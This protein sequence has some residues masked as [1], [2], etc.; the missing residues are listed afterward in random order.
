[1]TLKIDF[2][3]IG[4]DLFMATLLQLFTYIFLYIKFFGFLN[5]QGKQVEVKQR[6]SSGQIISDD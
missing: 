1:M 4:E 6:I 2:S 5:I 3:S